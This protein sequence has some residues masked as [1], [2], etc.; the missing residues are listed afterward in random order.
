MSSF[1]IL[2]IPFI[3]TMI[4][5]FLLFFFKRELNNMLNTIFMAF[6]AGIM[7]S[8]SIWSLILPSI[9]ITGSF[10]ECTIGLII[11]II[12]F[13]IIDSL[14]IK[15]DKSSMIMISVTLHNI[16]EG[17]VVGAA[18]VAGL[19]SNIYSLAACISLAL[20]IG[21]QNIPEG[22]I[23]SL[24][25][26]SLGYNNK[27]AFMYGFI[28]AVIEPIFGLLTIILANIIVPILPFLL[29]FAAGA[30]IYVVI[31]ELLPETQ[32]NNKKVGTI[33]FIIGFLIMMI[34][35]VTLS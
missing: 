7:L 17:M 27:K 11:G 15:N 2:L 8:A 10:I 22:A 3:G 30:M 13:L 35:D 32:L 20:G 33:S 24:P 21:I 6:S 25:L 1:L 31:N 14:N 28:S 5:V 23:I 34:L 16:P 9:E 26:K 18:I 19:S 4:G 12:F 29:S